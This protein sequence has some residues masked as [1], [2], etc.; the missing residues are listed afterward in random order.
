M[1]SVWVPFT[2]EAKEAI[3]EYDEIM[4]EVKLALQECGRKL[5]TWLRKRQR[6]KS[7]LDRRETFFKYI[8]EVAES[9]G[10]IK[11]G[12]INV[13]KLKKSLGE[14]ARQVTG[15]DKTDEL[16]NLKPEEDDLSGLTK[17]IVLTEDGLKGDIKLKQIKN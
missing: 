3:A 4:E 5:G 9:V 16:L 11:C 17:T 6:A 1:A 12:K 14:I 8:E 7:E 13:E 15:C 2:S 10:R